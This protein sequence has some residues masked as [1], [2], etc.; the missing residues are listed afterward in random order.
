[1]TLSKW[2][3]MF[4]RYAVHSISKMK[5]V[6]SFTTLVTSC[7]GTQCN[8]PG[9]GFPNFFAGRPLLDSKNNHRSA[10]PCSCTYGVSG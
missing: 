6:L 2:L 9:Q 7:P 10:H 1:M 4:G 5:A 8:I 3:A